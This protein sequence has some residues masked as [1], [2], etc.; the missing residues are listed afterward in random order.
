MAE[1]VTPA[2]VKAQ[3]RLTESELAARMTEVL[4]LI[5]QATAIVLAHCNTTEHWRTV[6]AAWVDDTTTPQ[7]VRTAIL[8]QVAYLNQSRGDEPKGAV[9]DD[10]LAP[11]VKALLRLYSDP[12]IA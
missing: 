3:L 5:D 7:A 4:S 1:L 6:T 9:E 10:G 12:V 8:K 2:D 11:G